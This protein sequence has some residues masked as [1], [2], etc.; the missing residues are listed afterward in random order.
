[1][2]SENYTLVEGGMLLRTRLSADLDHHYQLFVDATAVSRSTDQHEGEA[3]ARRILELLDESNIANNWRDGRA[4][5]DL[6]IQIGYESR[7]Y[8]AYGMSAKLT[9]PSVS[10][11]TASRVATYA[12]QQ[13]A[14]NLGT[15][16]AKDIPGMVYA[17]VSQSDGITLET[18]P[19]GSSS[20]D[21]DGNEYTENSGKISLYAHNL[22]TH[23]IQLICISGLIA[24]AKL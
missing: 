4:D 14:Y 20:M 5:V 8:G 22:Y 18:N 15:Y 2:S 21:T 7:G 9:R 16:S 3:K 11:T 17:H 19:V 12:M 23:Q 6:E 1:M 24:L 13:M 10:D